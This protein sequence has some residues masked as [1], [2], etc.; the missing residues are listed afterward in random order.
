MT[1]SEYEFILLIMN[2]KKYENK[3]NIQKH[4]QTFAKFAKSVLGETDYTRLLNSIGYT[5]YENQDAHETIYHYSME[6]NLDVWKGF[7]VPWHDLGEKLATSIGKNNIRFN[8]KVNNIHSSRKDENVYEVYTQTNEIF[9]AKKVVIATTANQV[10]ALLPQYPMYENVDGQP[11]LRVYGKFDKHSVGIMKEVVPKFTYVD[12]PLEKIIPID[13]EKGVYMIV[14]NDNANALAFKP[15]IENTA[16]N[17]RFFE[18]CIETTLRIPEG[19]LHL[20]DIRSYFWNYGT[21]YYKPLD[22]S[23][24][25]TREQYIRKA[26]RPQQ[27]L[28]VVGEML[29]RNQGWVE[30]ALESVDEVISEIEKV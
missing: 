11:F 4:P 8:K 29:S 16:K 1:N 5:D 24:F 28:F 14:Y 12:P 3:A 26:Q 23:E 19:S 20:T 10:R 17:C 9:Q 15:Y 30:G 22:K 18:K 21:H 7:S 25:K 2:C 27:N 13:T 6:D